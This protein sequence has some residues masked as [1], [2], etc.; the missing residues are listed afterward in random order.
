M[1][2]PSSHLK[3]V[4]SFPTI[5]NQ[6]PLEISLQEP[7]KD[8]GSF[9][10]PANHGYEQKRTHRWHQRK[11][12]SRASWAVFVCVPVPW[13][14]F[15]VLGIETTLQFTTAQLLRKSP[16]DISPR[17]PSARLTGS[18]RGWAHQLVFGSHWK[19][20]TRVVCFVAYQR[21]LLPS[22][23]S[24]PHSSV[25]PACWC[26]RAPSPLLVLFS[27][28]PCSSSDS[29]LFCPA[30]L[31]SGWASSPCPFHWLPEVGEKNCTWLLQKESLSCTHISHSII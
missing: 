29:L 16:K 24:Y 12:T 20:P 22:S 27:A 6:P 30:W 11:C 3:T 13:V 15:C 4:L 18:G 7:L 25:T 8:R 14:A 1:R 28:L 23:P 17:F 31:T 9:L 5:T 2:S 21:Q 19:W 10:R 26:A